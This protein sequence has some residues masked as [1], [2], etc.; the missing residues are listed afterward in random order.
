[1]AMG[2]TTQTKNQF[3]CKTECFDKT[4]DVFRPSRCHYP[5]CENN[6][7]FR[8]FSWIWR[9]TWNII[10][11]TYVHSFEFECF[12]TR[13]E[14]I[15]IQERMMQPAW[16]HITFSSL[17]DA[18]YSYCASFI[19]IIQSDEFKMS[20]QWLLDVFYMEITR[21]AG[22]TRNIAERRNHSVVW[23]HEVEVIS[24]FN[25]NSD[26]NENINGP[27]IH[28]V[29]YTECMYRRTHDLLSLFLYRF[30]LYVWECL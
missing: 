10:H 1:M 21:K 29:L 3:N 8:L 15:V 25:F 17:P 24:H 16:A 18:S 12:S 4:N 28:T 5:F 9:S 6:V 30:Q 22:K 26:W 23:M 11:I 14:F 2:K 20:C 19:R 7:N 27:I 13:M